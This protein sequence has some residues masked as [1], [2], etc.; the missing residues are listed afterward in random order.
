M[1]ICTIN[2]LLCWTDTILIQTPVSCNTVYRDDTL[3]KSTVYNWYNQ[4]KNTQV[5]S[6]LWV[7][8]TKPVTPSLLCSRSWWKKKK[9]KIWTISHTTYSSNNSP[10]HFRPFPRLR[11]GLKYHNF[12]SMEE[13][14][15]NET[16][17]LT[18]TPKE[19][20]QKSFQ[21]WQGYWNKCCM[22]RKAAIQDDWVRSYMFPFLL[23][24]MLEFR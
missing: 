18:V 16:V 7:C 21:Q 13:I 17:G 24:H 2:K 3:S 10:R 4:V 20:F 1:Y 23:Q 9:N 15:H 14:E 19:S 11:L 5:L 12:V 8:E 22:F 6:V